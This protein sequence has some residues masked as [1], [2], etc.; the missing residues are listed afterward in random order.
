MQTVT[1]NNSVEM[2]I[3]GFGVC[4]IPDN[5]THASVEAALEIG[6][7]HLDTASSYQNEEAVGAVIK[8]SGITR[9]NL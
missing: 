5:E 9:E 1:L 8:A 3:I 4:Q 7:R 6:Y 2:P